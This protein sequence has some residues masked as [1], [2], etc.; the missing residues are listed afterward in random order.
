[1]A[2]AARVAIPAGALEKILAKR[3]AFLVGRLSGA[4][5]V[6]KCTLNTLGT[7]SSCEKVASSLT[8]LFRGGVLLNGFG[9]RFGSK[10]DLDLSKEGVRVCYY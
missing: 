9:R 7:F 1:M 8:A 5:F 2:E 6:R 4:Y 3:W 10:G